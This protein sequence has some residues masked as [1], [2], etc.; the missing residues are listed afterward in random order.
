MIQCLNR[1]DWYELSNECFKMRV[2][3]YP[4]ATTDDVCNNQKS[5]IWK[6]IDLVTIHAGGTTWRVSMNL[7]KII[8]VW[9]IQLD[10]NYKL[11]NLSTQ[12]LPQ[13]AWNRQQKL[14]I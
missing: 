14:K 2:K 11:A 10:L 13:Y 6:K 9:Q 8:S 1:I 3:N 7:W 12:T 5:E 4:V